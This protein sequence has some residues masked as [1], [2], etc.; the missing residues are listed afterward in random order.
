MPTQ[1]IAALLGA[2]CCLRLA[3][4]LRHVATGWPKARNMLRPTMMRHIALAWFDRL[5]GALYVCLSAL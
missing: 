3:K 4:V 2:T 5:A 1:H